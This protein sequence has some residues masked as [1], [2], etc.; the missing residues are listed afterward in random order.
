M[1]GSMTFWQKCFR[2]S[3]APSAPA[4][5]RADGYTER[6][7]KSVAVFGPATGQL[8]R[9]QPVGG[10]PGNFL[11]TSMPIPDRTCGRRAMIF[12]VGADRRV[13]NN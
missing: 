6:V 1:S 13:A 5:K 10:V 11:K 8:R 4:L 9:E 2:G 3:A 12:P 7:A